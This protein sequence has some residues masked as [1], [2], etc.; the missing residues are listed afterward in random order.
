MLTL[1]CF[2]VFRL[3]NSVVM[4]LC[5]VGVSVSNLGDTF[6]ILHVVCDG[7]KQK[8]LRSD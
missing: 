5:F 8:V 1:S 6:M 7:P 4:S 2:S 3:G